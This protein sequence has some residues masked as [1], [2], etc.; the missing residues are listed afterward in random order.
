MKKLIIEVILINT[1]SILWSQDNFSWSLL[2]STEGT[3][4]PTSFSRF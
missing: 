2:L 1:I 4:P 3:E